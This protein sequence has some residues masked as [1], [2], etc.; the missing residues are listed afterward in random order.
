MV[1]P[2]ADCIVPAKYGCACTSKWLGEIV[3]PNESW[4]VKRV[5]GVVFLKKL[6]DVVA[7]NFRKDLELE[8]K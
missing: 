2:I 6:L 1:L 7:L 3:V 4:A 5:Q 8:I